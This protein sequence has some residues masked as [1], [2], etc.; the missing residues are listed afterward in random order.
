MTTC[1]ISHLVPPGFNHT[2][3]TRGRRQEVELVSHER[4]RR[5]S[6]ALIPLSAHVAAHLH[7]HHFVPWPTERHTLPQLVPP[8]RGIAALRVRPL[9]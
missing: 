1:E 9:P 4:V 8:I 5:V 2:V 7:L 3:E 6:V